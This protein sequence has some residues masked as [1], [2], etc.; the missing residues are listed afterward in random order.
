M[1]KNESPWER[2][3]SAAMWGSCVPCR[4]FSLR[5]PDRAQ[6]TVWEYGD[7]SAQTLIVVLPVGI[8]APTCLPVLAR[9]A[10]LFR[11]VTWHGRGHAETA[12]EFDN[13]NL[14][15]D[16]HVN[17]LMSVIA[18]LE[19][20][21]CQLIGIC[22]GAIVA[23]RASVH[24]NVVRSV[25][26]VCGYLNLQSVA[27]ENAF[28]RNAEL[29]FRQMAE[30]RK[31]AIDMY[32]IAQIIFRSEKSL[33][34]YRHFQD[35]ERFCRYV[36]SVYDDPETAYRYS[37]LLTTLYDEPVSSWLSSVA[38]PVLLIRVRDDLIVPFG[39]A[40]YA[41]N[42]LTNAQLRTYDCGG[43]WALLTESQIVDA[44]TL[45]LQSRPSGTACI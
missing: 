42:I 13:L 24:S 34:E 9:M 14:S 23:L 37:R 11:V 35:P 36:T 26:S 32:Q 39:W 7:C 38:V 33:A 6:L 43:H 8:Q 12:E 3:D 29:V 22:S 41:K 20:H 28:T 2:G 4:E 40:E 10:Q 16:S 45:F 5:A 15:A 27:G 17:D 1:D 19:I 25:V 18:S 44:I 30:S 31:K 21:S